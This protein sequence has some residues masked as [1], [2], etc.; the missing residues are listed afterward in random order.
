MG[1]QPEAIVAYTRAMKKTH[2]GAIEAN[3]LAMEAHMGV[4]ASTGTTGAHHGAMD[5]H[6]RVFEAHPGV[7]KAQPG[8]E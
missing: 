1:A 4:I 3:L 8:S 5:T 6:P 2:P 7:V